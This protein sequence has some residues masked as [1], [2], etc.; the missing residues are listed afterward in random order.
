VL[1][2]PSPLCAG[3]RCDDP[4][5][6]NLKV[7]EQSEVIRCS[8]GRST[9]ARGASARSRRGRRARSRWTGEGNRRSIVPLRVRCSTDGQK[10]RARRGPTRDGA[11]KVAGR[12]M[13]SWRRPSPPRESNAGCE[14][15]SPRHRR[16]KP[17]SGVSTMLERLPTAS[18]VRNSVLASIP[19]NPAGQLSRAG[20]P[21]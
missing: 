14:S 21:R 12:H 18:I 11:M 8:S 10:A 7:A 9:S 5:R 1:I 4:G 3:E 17:G 20:L 19:G 16:P 13:H 6:V 2:R 15:P